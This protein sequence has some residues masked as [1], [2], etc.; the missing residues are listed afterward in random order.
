LIYWLDQN[1]K[2]TINW[3]QTNHGAIAGPSDVQA[4]P[5]RARPKASGPPKEPAQ[6]PEAPAK[7]RA[8]PWRSG[9]SV[10]SRMTPPRT[11]TM[12]QRGRTPP[13]RTRRSSRRRRP[14]C[15]AR[16]REQRSGSQCITRC[17]SVSV[18]LSPRN[19]SSADWWLMSVYGPTLLAEKAAF[20]DELRSTEQ[21]CPGPS[22]YC[23]DFNMIYLDQDKNEGVLH[24]SWMRRSRRVIDDLQLAEVHLHGASTPGRTSAVDRPLNGWIAYSP[25]LPG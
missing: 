17:Y 24:R 12:P 15:R 21:S 18:V 8:R 11:R 9:S 7:G 3:K 25:R 1:R 13:W 4:R 2:K 10:A 22:L 19:G 14:R 16:W 20:L 6:G 23:G 5:D